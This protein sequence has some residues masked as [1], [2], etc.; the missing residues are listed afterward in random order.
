VCIWYDVSAVT[1]WYDVS[2]VTVWFWLGRSLAASTCS[3]HLLA[4]DQRCWSLPGLWEFP[5]DSG[6]GT[7]GDC[8]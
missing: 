3:I 1:V 2:A 6:S 5:S 4:T 8:R 7:V